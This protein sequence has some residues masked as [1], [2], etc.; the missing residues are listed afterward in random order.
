[1]SASNPRLQRT[2]AALPP[3]PLS[4][5]PLGDLK[6]RRWLFGLALVVSACASKPA[7][8][9]EFG[10]WGAISPVSEQER[11]VMVAAITSLAAVNPD[12]VVLSRY[13]GDMKRRVDLAPLA[14]EIPI[15]VDVDVRLASID[16]GPPAGRAKAFARA[17]PGK[18]TILEISVPSLH[19]GSAT[20]TARIWDARA[21][22]CWLPGRGSK[23]TLMHDSNKWSVTSM[24]VERQMSLAQTDCP[25]GRLT[26]GCSGLRRLCR[27]RR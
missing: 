27:R 4:R 18:T 25:C 3:S 24:T 1:M 26:R 11:P 7:T 14:G 8:P 21:W 20:I 23:I 16:N 9:S 13:T 17:F 12:S 22:E 6:P 5:N 10:P 19:G 15:V 2:P